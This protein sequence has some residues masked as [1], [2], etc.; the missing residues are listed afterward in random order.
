MSVISTGNYL[1]PVLCYGILGAGGVFSA[2][3][4]ASTASEL[5]KQIEGAESRILCSVEA[6]RDV[7]V[8]AAEKAGWGRNGGGRV[9][10]MSEGREWSLRAVQADGQLGL[11]LIDESQRL[12][13]E[14][15]TD[16][17]TLDNSLIILIYSSGTTGLP[18]GK[19][20]PRYLLSQ[21]A[22][23]DQA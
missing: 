1:L 6:T 2:A 10:V 20:N 15:I 7:A 5:C 12:P 4:A 22:N 11:N 21:S 16:R 18:K 13:W 23:N 17:E 14:R 9:L 19:P 8:K 3:S